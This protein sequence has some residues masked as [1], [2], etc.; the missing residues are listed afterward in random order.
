MPLDNIKS[1]ET[2]AMTLYWQALSTGSESDYVVFAHILDE[3]GRLIGQHDS[4]PANSSRPTT[5][6]L[7]GEFIEDQHDIPLRE[8]DYRGQAFVEIGLY[9]PV[10]GTRLQ[11]ADGS[12]Q[13][14]L[15]IT[16]N[17]E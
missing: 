15:P 3:E 13:L 11:L 17:V 5:G 8:K 12:D 7:A 4:T 9:D 16:V 1:D 14:L 2:V 6:W 10:T